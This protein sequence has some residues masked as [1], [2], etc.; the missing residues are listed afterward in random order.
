[1]KK[2]HLLIAI[3]ILFIG[4]TNA[5]NEKISGNWLLTKVEQGDEVDNPLFT[6]NFKEDGKMEVMDQELGTWKYDSENELITMQSTEVKEFDG[7]FKIIL[8]T[9]K[10]LQLQQ[11]SVKLYYAKINL[12]DKEK[13]NAS[14]NIEGE[15]TIENE[16]DQT[17]LLKIERPDTFLISIIYSGGGSAAYKGT[18]IYNPEEKSILFLGGTSLIKGFNTVKT[19]SENKFILEK[20]GKEIIGKKESTAKPIERLTFTIEDFPEESTDSS[21]WQDFDALLNELKHVS[22][23]KYKQSKLIPNTSSFTYNT[24]LSKIDVNSEERRISLANLSI[25]KKDTMQ[26][27]ERVKGDLYNQYNDF[28]PQEEL[29]PFKLVTTETIKVPAGEFKCEIFEGF[30]GDAKVKYW[31]IIDKPGIYAKIIREDIGLFD[32]VEYSIIELEEIKK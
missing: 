17:Q 27:S 1:M 11:G 30:D 23:L 31:M 4:F 21:P 7:N 19:I 24:L 20:N 25:T 6:Q 29:G 13:N 14:L 12:A 28:F 5:Q 15:W 9:P 32:K 3:F 16:L 2:S 18:W 26:F 22:H 10:K 8:I